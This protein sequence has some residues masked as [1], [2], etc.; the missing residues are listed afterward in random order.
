M[1]RAYLQGFERTIYDN[2]A[3]SLDKDCFSDFYVIKQNEYMYLTH[4]DPFENFFENFFPE[5]Q[6]L[7]LFFH[8]LGTQCDVG[9]TMNEFMV[10][11]WYKGCW[12]KQILNDSINRVWYILR[13]INTAAIL[14]F[15]EIPSGDEIDPEADPQPYLKIAEQ[16]GGSVAVILKELTDFKPVPREE[17]T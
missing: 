16:V 17:R 8:M 5:I 4:A 2:Q 12:P 15:E 11:C 14:W 10:F 3:I 1:I 7:Y 13:E 9:D 6:I